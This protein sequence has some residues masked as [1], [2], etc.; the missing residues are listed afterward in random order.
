ME[1]QQPKRPRPYRSARAKLNRAKKQ[2][3]NLKFRIDAFL[4]REPHPYEFTSY[5]DAET[6]SYVYKTIRVDEV[7]AGIVLRAGE[8]LQSLRSALD[9]LAWQAVLDA[10]NKPGTY[11]GFPILDSAEKYQSYSPGKIEGVGPRERNIINW[12]RPYKGGNDILW[13]LHRLNNIDKHRLIIAAGLA[14]TERTIFPSELKRAKKSFAAIHGNDVPFPI[15][16]PEDL[17][18]EATA[19]G[20][21]LKTDEVFLSVPYSDAKDDMHFTFEIAFDEPG[22]LTGQPILN[23]MYDILQMVELIG[24]SFEE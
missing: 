2:I 18:V 20:F 8:T 17:S 13:R 7:P 19:C 9:H 22:I 15:A 10:G 6:G 24:R 14:L 12:F 23:A 16:R 5:Q 3:K 21:P 1:Q 11:T 4:F